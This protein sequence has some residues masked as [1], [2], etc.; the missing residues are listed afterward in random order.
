MDKQISL[1]KY[2][3][4]NKDLIIRNINYAFFESNEPFLLSVFHQKQTYFIHINAR[5]CKDYPKIF[6]SI[7]EYENYL[8]VYGTFALLV[9]ASFQVE[10]LEDSRIFFKEF[11]EELTFKIYYDEAFRLNLESLVDEKNKI[12]KYVYRYGY[13]FLLQCF[14]FFYKDT[15]RITSHSCIMKYLQMSDLEFRELFALYK[16]KIILENEYGF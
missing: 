15:F 12:L 4:N 10:S 16:S 2:V 1:I 8:A 9:N 6:D 14:K 5:L 11:L 7:Y 13:D 3:K